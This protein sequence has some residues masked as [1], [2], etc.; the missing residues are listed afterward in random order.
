MQ[1]SRELWNG[2]A[3]TTA[4]GHESVHATAMNATAPFSRQNSLY[5]KA[6]K[7]SKPTCTTTRGVRRFS[8]IGMK[9][10]ATMLDPC[11]VTFKQRAG[12]TLAMWTANFTTDLPAMMTQETLKDR[13]LI[14]TVRNYNS[15]RHPQQLFT[16]AKR[17]MFTGI[18]TNLWCVPPQ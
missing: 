6:A 4:I 11:S 9:W 15:I 1:H 14:P 17:N 5:T 13:H 7:I 2:F 10:A 12:G 16:T 8:S 18:N 3:T